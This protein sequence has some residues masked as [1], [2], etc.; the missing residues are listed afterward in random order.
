MNINL[1]NVS[2]FIA[3]QGVDIGLKIIGAIVAW[4][5]GR[6][7]INLAVG[8]MG[9][10]LDRAGKLD[11][12]LVKYLKSIV[13][14]LL[15]VVLILAILGLFGVE[16]TSFAALLAGAGLAIGTAW[17]GL[18]AHFAAGVFMQV[19]RP[20]KVGDFVQAGGVTGTVTELGL[21]TTTIVTPD[22]VT[23]I[24]GN[25]K[26]FSDIS[27]TTARCRCAA[28]TAWPRLPT[29]WM[30]RTPSPACAR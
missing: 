3:T 23:T 2:T 20:Y 11:P 16:T 25:N 1:D 28:W 14:V 24:V 18:L 22:N 7:L 27:R 8:L 17:G 5:I 4:I 30:C 10:G 19:L 15:T 29:A 13:S 26:I 21:F 12:T 9:K 6:W